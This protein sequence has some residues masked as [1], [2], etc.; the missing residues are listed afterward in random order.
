MRTLTPLRLSVLILVA[1]VTFLACGA[2]G[3]WAYQEYT[4]YRQMQTLLPQ[5]INVINAHEQ[6]LQKITGAPTIAPS[7]GGGASPGGGP[8]AG[9]PPPAK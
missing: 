7:T 9:A 6:V 1:L 4:A 5:M 2:A 3:A 8:G